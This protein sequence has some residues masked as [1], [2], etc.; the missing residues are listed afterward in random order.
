MQNNPSH[1]RKSWPEGIIDNADGDSEVLE[2]FLKP[3]DEKEKKKE[4][5]ETYPWTLDEDV[6]ATQ[7]SITTAED[8]TKAVLTE[9]ATKNGGLD[10]ISV[11]DNTK[12]VF[13]S[14]LPYAATA[15][16]AR[17]GNNMAAIATV[18]NANRVPV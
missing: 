4:K 1:W 5:K 2:M 10:M 11:Y 7:K 9:P 8:I 6:I 15:R 3:E 14:G 16:D 18:A 12:R 13:E 17:F